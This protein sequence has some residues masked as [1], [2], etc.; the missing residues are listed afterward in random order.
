MNQHFIFNALNS[1]QR[2][3]TIEAIRKQQKN[4][5]Q[6]FANTNQKNFRCFDIKKKDRTDEIDI[7]TK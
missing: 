4:K 7:L 6:K 2:I 3:Y 5:W 1:I